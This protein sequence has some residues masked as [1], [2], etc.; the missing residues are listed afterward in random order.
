VQAR[1]Q[2]PAGFAYATALDT[3]RRTA[4]GAVFEPAS[5]EQLVDSPVLAGR[6][7]TRLRVDP[8]HGPPVYLDLFGDTA[9]AI[10]PA[11]SQIASLRALLAE[12]RAV[13]P[14][15]PYAHYVF[16]VSL[17]DVL[18]AGGGT[19]HQQSTEIGLAADGLVHWDLHLQDHLLFA[20]E[21]VHAWNG[22]SRQPEGLW[23]PDFNTP[24]RDELLWVY[25]GQ[26]ELWGQVFAARS[27]FVTTQQAL[28]GIALLAARAQA[29]VGRRWKSLRDST[30]DPIYRAGRPTL[31]PDWQGRE[32]YY[33]DG[34]LLWLDVD[35]RLRERTHG[36][37]GLDDFARAFLVAEPRGLAISTYRFE[38]VCAT[39]AKLAPG[40]WA[41]VLAQHLDAH[42][43]THLLDGLRR[44]G[45]ELVF[46]DVP[47]ELF[48]QAETDAGVIDLSYSLGL[49]IAE[50][51]VKRV[52]WEG[53]AYQAGLGPGAKIVSLDGHPYTD[54][55]LVAAITPSRRAPLAIGVRAD[56]RDR[57]V[58]IDYRGPLRYPRLRRIAG[59]PARL[60][61]LLAPRI[62]R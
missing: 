6:Y 40:D 23:T 54:A 3:A 41:G 22:K 4:D 10:A 25:E 45:Y 44:G 53:P 12:T 8:G 62:R 27:G 56:G 43:E 51:V 60:D 14:S 37:R 35:M 17:S 26:T 31:W 29:R 47:T 32:D 30:F 19:E 20:H 38:D 18:P 52:T 2:L 50:G 46:T 15:P 16:L 13:M 55:A 21:L 48:R 59:T 49:A 39:L 34:P 58:Q 28:D 36:N 24:M 7:M 61:T 57:V 9:Q 11:E 33:V 42:D 5:L 1:V